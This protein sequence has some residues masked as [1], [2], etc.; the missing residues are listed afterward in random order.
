M[1]C[2]HTRTVGACGVG[3]S[4]HGL[5]TVD[6]TVDTPPALVAAVRVVVTIMDILSIC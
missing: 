4:G 1:L 2:T 5:V 3:P 6:V